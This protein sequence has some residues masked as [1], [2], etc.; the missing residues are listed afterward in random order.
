MSTWIYLISAAAPPETIFG[1]DA[2]VPPGKL[3]R[4][5]R[6]ADS[7]PRGARAFAAPSRRAA[8]TAAA[9][10]LIADLDPALAETDFGRWAGRDLAAVLAD[11]PDA[12]A[13]WLNDPSAAPHGGETLA[14]VQAR[15]ADWL[16][17]RAAEGGQV[18]A[19]SH[20]GPIRAAVLHALGAPL[21][22]AHRIDVAP[23]SRV[24]LT[25]DAR[26]WMWRSGD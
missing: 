19:I 1:H 22:I 16:E 7:L 8:Q 6:L 17:A 13:V 5:T 20:P 2:E 9:L 15:V 26:R 18:I 24:L 23:L 10:G 12:V 14:D 3:I 4:A 11:T 21:T 25:H